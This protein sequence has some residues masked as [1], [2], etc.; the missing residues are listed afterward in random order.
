VAIDGTS[1]PVQY[2]GAQSG[3]PGLDQVNVTLPISL[4][5]AGVASVVLTV[6]GQVSNTVTITIQ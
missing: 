3:Y 6:D 2:A 5:G 1:V 4:N